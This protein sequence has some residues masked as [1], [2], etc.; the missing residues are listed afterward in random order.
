MVL[1]ETPSNISELILQESFRL[2]KPGGKI[3]NLDANQQRLRKAQWLIKLF[4]EPY[5]AIYAQGDLKEWLGKIGFQEIIC[6][7]IGWIYRVTY[8]LKK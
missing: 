3:I 8:G 6:Q 4:K 2:L 1:H 7:P 5:S